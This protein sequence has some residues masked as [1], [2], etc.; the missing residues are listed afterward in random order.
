MILATPTMRSIWRFVSSRSGWTWVTEVF[1]RLDVEA[2][3]QRDVELRRQVGRI[4]A[5]VDANHVQLAVGAHLGALGNHGDRRNHR[6]IGGMLSCC[7]RST[8]PSPWH[9]TGRIPCE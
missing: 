8:R 5:V 7:V 9:A 6:R 2:Y 1:E 3:R 4:A